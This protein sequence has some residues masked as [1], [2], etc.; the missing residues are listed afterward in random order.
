MQDHKRKDRDRG[1][2]GRRPNPRAPNREAAAAI[3][4][5]RAIASTR[6]GSIGR[7][8]RVERGED[9]AAHNRRRPPYRG[10]LAQQ[11]LDGALFGEARATVDASREM[12]L[13][14]AQLV[15]A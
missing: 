12:L 3:R 5:G 11:R 1:N 4:A 10:A 15:G 9:R 8:D 13:D 2:R 14:L 6:A 7:I